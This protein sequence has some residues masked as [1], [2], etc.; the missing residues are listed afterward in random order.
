MGP[1]TKI[2][3]MWHGPHRVFSGILTSA[4]RSV[5]L[6]AVA[7]P[8]LGEQIAWVGRLCLQFSAQLTHMH[9]EGGG[10]VWGVRAPDLVQQ[11]AVRHHLPGVAHERGQEFVLDWG[12]M[13]W[14]PGDRPQ[15]SK[16]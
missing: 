8:Q 12:K 2:D 10:V 13:D 4:L 6:E 3:S 7:D 11:L 15:E 1:T 16:T 14:L 9:P 5:R